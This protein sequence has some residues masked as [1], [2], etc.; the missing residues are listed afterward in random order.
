MT[1]ER[2]MVLYEKY[3]SGEISPEEALLLRQYR[4]NF[5]LKEDLQASDSLQESAIG[6]K[7]LDRID[8]TI[9]E[10]EVK[11]PT[12]R[13]WIAAAAAVFIGILSLSILYSGQKTEKTIRQSPHTAKTNV[14]TPGTNTAI[15]TL[16]DGSD[17]ILDDAGNGEIAQAGPVSVKKLNNGQL[18]YDAGMATGGVKSNA[19]HTISTPRGGR[20]AVKLPDGTNVWLNSAS[21]L[22]YP[23]A[24][25]GTDRQVK[26]RGEAYFEVAKNREKPFLV[27]VGS[28]T[29]KVLGTHFNINAYKAQT[30]IKTTLLEGSVRMSNETS[31][32]LLAPGQQGQAGTASAGINKKVVDT[33]QVMAWKN[34][35][36]IFRDD[37]IREVMDQIS[38]WYDVEVEYRC[39]TKGKNFG[40]IYSKNKDIN[41]LLKGLELTG[42]I[43]F[44]IEGRRIIVMS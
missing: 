12:Y 9:A 20:Y 41:E 24:F 38:R 14:I 43:H 29:V 39:D 27:E 10:Q 2:Y 35:Y 1:P 19:L 25:S 32:I 18:A 26:L 7:I 37:N 23:V 16:S 15:L 34:G 31:S 21:S 42:N 30:D 11:R 36:F 33:D 3:I 28:V 44:K 13:W 8:A 6:K 22:T 5:S 17:I 40:G 4:D